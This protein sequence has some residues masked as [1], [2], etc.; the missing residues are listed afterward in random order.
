MSYREG[1]Q[2]TGASCSARG[3][4]EQINF[5]QGAT[6]NFFRA[7]DAV[8]DLAQAAG[9][10]CWIGRST[11]LYCPKHGPAASTVERGRTTRRW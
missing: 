5:P 7:R 11:W 3:C 9:W 8:T 4:T 1:L 10:S 6:M 2:C